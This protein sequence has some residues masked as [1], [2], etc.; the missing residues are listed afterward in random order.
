MLIGILYIY[1]QTG[2]TDYETLTV[3]FTLKE[4]KLLWLAF[5]ASFATKIPMVPV[6][7]AS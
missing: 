5:F 7:L 2:T 1:Y 4:E 6:H 3:V